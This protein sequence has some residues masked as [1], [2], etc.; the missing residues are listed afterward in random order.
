MDTS[1]LIVSH[2]R[3]EELSFT[4]S[5]LEQYIDYSKHEILVF[6][7]GCNDNSLELQTIFPR[8]VWSSSNKIL[9]ASGARN[10]LYKKAK[11]D[12]LIGLDDDAHPLHDDFITRTIRLFE[13]YPD[14]GIIAYQELKGVVN[15]NDCEIIDFNKVIEEYFTNEFIGCGFAVKKN[16]Y[17]QTRGFPVWVDIYGEESCVAI[18]V[19]SKGYNILYTN[20]ITVNHRV[21]ILQRKLNEQNYY[22]FGKQLKNRAY[23]YVVYYKYPF[24]DIL[25]L[26]RHNFIKYGLMDFKYFK[27]FFRTIF[28]ILLGIPRVLKYRNP[29]DNKR[30]SEINKLPKLK[31]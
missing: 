3:K 16:V 12:I 26:L 28:E 22:R 5:K 14:V 2:N 15:F 9:G 4:L 24:R 11:G 30:I 13:M 25:K 8:V 7:D 1:I 19:L 10:V 20:R 18:E 21:N 27:I 29:I 23:F 31:F 17:E 6:L